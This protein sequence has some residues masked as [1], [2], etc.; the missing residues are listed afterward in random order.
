MKQLKVGDRVRISM[1]SDFHYR[2]RGECGTITEVPCDV[3]PIEHPCVALLDTGDVVCLNA[4]EIQ[5]LRKP[6]QE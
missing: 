3:F 1:D 2:M 4:K 6:G 5:T